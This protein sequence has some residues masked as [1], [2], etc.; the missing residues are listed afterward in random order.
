MKKALPI[1]A[2][3]TLT[4]ACSTYVQEVESQNY[5]PVYLQ[6]PMYQAERQPTGSIYSTSAQGL[7]VQ[8]RRAAQIGDVLTVEL[9]ERFTASQS[10]TATSARSSSYQMDLPNILTGGFDDAL[11]TNGTTQSFNGN[12]SA[13]QSNSLRG[14]MTVQV[15]R[16][17]PGGMLEIMGEK[18]LT[19]NSG[20]E[21][22][23]I[24]GVVRPEDIGPDNVVPS[25]RIANARI[26]YVGAGDSADAARPGWLRR[27]LNTVSPL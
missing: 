27:G 3:L 20:A 16:Q 10:L 11:L 4:T 5:E 25:D 14:R 18:R 9:S 2:A 17:L 12:G 1:L 24:T 8:D 15:V 7:F 23:R 21:Y 26:E 19:L 22:I 6:E 13:N